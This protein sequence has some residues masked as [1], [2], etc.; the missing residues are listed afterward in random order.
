[1]IGAAIGIGWVALLAYVYS[2][3][4]V[5][6]VRDDRKQRRERARGFEVIP[7]E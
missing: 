4:F 2:R 5:E 3:A 6:D 7:R 1:M